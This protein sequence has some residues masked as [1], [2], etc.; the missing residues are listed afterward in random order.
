MLPSQCL[1]LFAHSSLM[2]QG[3]GSAWG[4]GKSVQYRLWL[5][6]GCCPLFLL[7][8][9]WAGQT[10]ASSRAKKAELQPLQ[11]KHGTVLQKF[12]KAFIGCWQHKQAT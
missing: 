3:L 9:L 8:Q 12:S 10:C 5:P 11:F 4:N 7:G 1:P 2:R 6:A